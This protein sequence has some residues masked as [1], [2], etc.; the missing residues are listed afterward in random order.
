MYHRGSVYWGDLRPVVGS[1]QDGVRPVL[2]VQ[3]DVGNKHAPT[4]IVAPLTCNLHQSK[5]LVTHV[6]TYLPN[7]QRSVILLEQIRTIDKTRLG[8]YITDLDHVTMQRVN[9][10][11]LRSLGL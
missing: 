3:N 9:Q 11:L 1:E 7:L 2:I 8:K 5:P 6:T 10:G 4:V